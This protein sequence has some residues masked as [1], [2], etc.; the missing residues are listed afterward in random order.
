MRAYEKSSLL[1]VNRIERCL[2]LEFL[3][4]FSLCATIHQNTNAAKENFFDE[5]DLFS[6]Y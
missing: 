2:N 1:I 6:A 5:N 3:C 4:F